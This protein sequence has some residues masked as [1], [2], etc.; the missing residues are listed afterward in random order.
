MPLLEINQLQVTT[1]DTPILKG[2]TLTVDVGEVV[3]VMGPNGS[4]KSTLAHVLMGHPAYEVTAGSVTF[5][6]HDLLALKPEARAQAGLFL[7]FQYPHEI[8]GVTIGNFLRLAYNSLHTPPLPVTAA[9]ARIKEKMD[10]LQIPHDFLLRSVNEGFSGGEKKRMEM[11]QLAMLEPR[12]AI[13]D[14]TDSGLDID[15][16]KIVG[17]AI[18]TIR[19]HHPH[20]ALLVITHYQRILDYIPADRIAIMRAGQI[21]REGTADLIKQIETHGYHAL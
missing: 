7:S 18:Q 5:E 2:V 15:A 3:A 20:L 13:L 14:E 9:V 10:L 8:A 11:L 6:G 4:G 21:V 17:H 12:L 1:A 16:L 19:Q